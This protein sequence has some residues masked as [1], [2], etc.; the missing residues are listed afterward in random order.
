MAQI[1]IR[2]LEDGLLAKL[3]AR[4]KANGRSAEAEAREA[5]KRALESPPTS[6][7]PLSELMGA[8][9]K[10]GRSKEEID[11]YIRALRDETL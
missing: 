6:P 1:L 5:L 2:R 3:K 9:S 8:G 10:W 7:R 11:A 4:A